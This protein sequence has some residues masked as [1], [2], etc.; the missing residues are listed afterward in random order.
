MLLEPAILATVVVSA[1]AA[2]TDLW[3]G[4]IPNWL[5]L[6]P[7]VV[8]PALHGWMYGTPGVA[9]AILGMI[10]CGL[11]PYLLFRVEAIGG[12]DVKLFAAIGAI[13]GVLVGGEILVASFA[14]ACVA[15]IALLAARRRLGHVLG[16]SARLLRNA[17]VSRRHRRAVDPASLTEMRLGPAVLAAVLWI[18]AGGS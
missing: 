3:R 16:T 11:M 14:I 6:P 18:V 1:I 9:F 15:A 8:A 12:G 13:D 7:L 10:G 5:T 4:V 17:F 2:F